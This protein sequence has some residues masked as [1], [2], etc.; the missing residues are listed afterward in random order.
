MKNVLEGI[1]G[2]AVFLCFLALV[3]AAVQA[4]WEKFWY[5]H[6]VSFAETAARAQ[7]DFGSAQ[8][9]IPALL[10]VVAVYLGGGAVLYLVIAVF[11][12]ARKQWEPEVPTIAEQDGGLPE[13]VEKWED[14]LDEAT[15]HTHDGRRICQRCGALIAA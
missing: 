8:T 7:V 15:G 6:S 2:C 10:W 3:W 13:T 9:A 14:L 11:L 5:G 1:G 12:W 4:G